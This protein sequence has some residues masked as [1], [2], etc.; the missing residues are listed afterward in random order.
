MCYPERSMQYHPRNKN[1]VLGMLLEAVY[2]SQV[3]KGAIDDNLLRWLRD[4]VEHCSA[5]GRCLAKC[6]QSLNIVKVIKAL[7]VKEDA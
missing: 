2:Y 6:P 5:C 3:N 1:M 4:L 7:G